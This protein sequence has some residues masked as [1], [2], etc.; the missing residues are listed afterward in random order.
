MEL[1]QLDR[2]REAM[3]R[4]NIGA[5][6]LTNMDSIAWATGFTGSNA[7]V[8][9]TA[10]D[11]LFI[12][13]SRYTIQAHEQ[14]EGLA[15]VTQTFGSTQ[16]D[17]LADQ[18]RRLG[19][20]KLSFESGFVTVSVFDDWKKKFEGVELSPA[21]NFVGPLRCIKL[22]H[23]VEKIKVACKMA[24]AC[25]EHVIRMIQ[26]GAAE[27][28]IGLDIE[29]F[30]R[31]QGAGLAFEPIVVSG[32]R[33][34][35]PHGSASQKKLEVG[36]FITLDFGCQ[37]DGYNSD[38][39]RTFVVGELTE[40][41]ERV[42]NQVLKANQTAIAAI[43]PGKTGKEIDQLAR[44]VLAEADM[45]QY[46]GHGLGHGLGRLVH[47]FGGLSQRSD[48]VLAPGMVMTVEPGV[49][50]EGFGGVR[51]ED[52]IVVTES[53]AEVLTCFPKKLLVLS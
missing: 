34:A 25:M 52:D 24:D 6:L 39:T 26:P 49:Y 35:R 11:G 42:Y 14:V 30:F 27:W 21:T 38:I 8:I 22:P 1:S 32:E 18:I 28:D 2:I 13:D 19:I 4:E 29:F 43:Q 20:E 9:L 44:D 37:V 3:V 50:I 48:T 41:H 10:S 5:M 31:R 17:F 23:E 45:A 33:S 51:I 12:T 46:M 15:V 47:D 40:R 16:A 36:D 53:G 7:Q